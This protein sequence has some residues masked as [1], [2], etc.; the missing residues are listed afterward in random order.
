MSV[1]RKSYHMITATGRI[2]IAA[3]PVIGFALAFSMPVPSRSH[4]RN[5]AYVYIMHK[6]SAKLDGNYYYDY[7]KEIAEKG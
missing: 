6:P 5:G 1:Y 4:P 3:A 2:A 7:N